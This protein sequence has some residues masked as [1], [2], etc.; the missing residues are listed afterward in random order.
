[1]QL[2][3]R[4]KQEFYEK[5]YLKVPGVVPQVMVNA[6]LRAINNSLGEGF[7]REELHLI[8]SQSYCK[9]LTHTPIISD[10]LNATPALALA[11]SLIGEGTVAPVRG[12]QIALRFPGMQDP[13]SK[14]SPHLDGMY[15]PYNGVT[16]GEIQNFTMLVGVLL[17]DLTDEYAG[18]F[19]TWPGTHHLYEQ[20]FREHGP[21]AILEGMPKVELPEPE[22]HLGKAGDIVLCHYEVAHAAAPNVSPHIRYAIFFRLNRE[23]H[24]ERV[25]TCLTDIWQEWDGMREIVAQNQQV[26]E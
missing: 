19:T 2:S 8:R 5:G 3:H 14:P 25:E 4:Q 17:S 1:M 22:Q 9:E 6:A 12:G 7:P 10:M 11:E 13:P 16:K 24:N 18:N 20:Y 23:G 15:T 26:S 21:H